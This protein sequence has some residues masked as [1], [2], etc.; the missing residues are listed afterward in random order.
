MACIYSVQK[1][2]PIL[3][4]IRAELQQSIDTLAARIGCVAFME[5]PDVV[6]SMIR[7]LR[8]IKELRK[9]GYTIIA[10]HWSDCIGHVKS[11]ELN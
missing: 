2:L 10:K 6:L 7:Y 3:D 8:R 4:N 1:V 11:I 5:R 9:A